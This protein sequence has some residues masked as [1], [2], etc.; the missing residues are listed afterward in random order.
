MYDIYMNNYNQYSNTGSAAKQRISTKDLVLTGMFT[1]VIS[2][3]AQI[4]IPV[5]PVPFTLQLIAVFLAGALLA[6]KYAFLSVLVY[7]LLGAAGVPVFANFDS[8]IKGLFGPTGGYLM[9]FPLMSLVTALFYKYFKRFK[10]FALVFGMLVSLALCY[11]LGTAWFTATNTNGFGFMKSLSLCVYP[12]ILFDTF[13]I[14]LAVSL[15]IVIRKA[16]K[17]SL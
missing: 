17:N 4:I 3:M 16:L 11:L 10:V 8:G 1:A 14:A 9:A 5:Q 15:S 12:F 13:K 6:P 2:V 7:L